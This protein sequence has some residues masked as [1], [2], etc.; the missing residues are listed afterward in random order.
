MGKQL[1]NGYDIKAKDKHLLMPQLREVS[2][3]IEGYPTESLIDNEARKCV[4]EIAKP[5]EF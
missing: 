5:I 2:E 3:S 4:L 1:G